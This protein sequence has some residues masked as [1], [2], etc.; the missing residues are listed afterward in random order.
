MGYTDSELREGKP[1]IGIANSWNT[2]VPGHYSLDKVAAYVKNGI[3]AGG[4]TPCEF[5]TIAAC[6]GVAQRHQGMHYILP[7]RQIICNSV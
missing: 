4:G 6:D 7:S 5:G 3:Y 1:L 2:L